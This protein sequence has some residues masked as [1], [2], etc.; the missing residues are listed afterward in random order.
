MKRRGENL[1]INVLTLGKSSKKITGNN[2]ILEVAAGWR[3]RWDARSLLKAFSQACFYP[4]CCCP[5]SE[6]LHEALSNNLPCIFFVFVFLSVLEYYF[7]VLNTACQLTHFDVRNHND[8][9]QI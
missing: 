6:V 1:E 3:D 2:E 9:K 8:V 4:R 5:G 7:Y